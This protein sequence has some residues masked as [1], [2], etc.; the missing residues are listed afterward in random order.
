MK[1]G[2]RT[3]YGSR[4][5]R[6]HTGTESIDGSQHVPS[7]G[8]GAAR[9]VTVRD[10]LPF[11]RGRNDKTIRRGGIKRG[12]RLWAFGPDAPRYWLNSYALKR[13]ALPPSWSERGAP[14]KR[15][16]FAWRTETRDAA[17]AQVTEAGA[18]PPVSRPK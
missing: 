6:P 8:V 10:D 2:F 16:V 12:A 18:S 4:T 17:C 13:C 9:I 11:S 7:V 1:L 5:I 14:T 15:G 3:T